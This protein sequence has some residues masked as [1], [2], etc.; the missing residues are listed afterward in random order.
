MRSAPA[1]RPA[2]L[3]R[4]ALLAL[5]VLTLAGAAYGL[6]SEPAGAQ[7]SPAAGPSFTD[8]QLYRDDVAFARH[9]ST[10]YARVMDEQR[11]RSYPMRPFVTVRP[12]TLAFLLAG[13]PGG[14]TTG[15][16]LIGA[17]AAAVVGLWTVRLVGPLGAPGAAVSGVALAGGVVAAFTP[18]GYLM[19]ECWAGLL[20]ALS[21]GLYPGDTE[22]ARTPRLAASIAAALAAA[23]IRELA[24]PYLGVMALTALAERRGKEA[25]AWL[26]AIG[27]YLLALAAHALMVMRHTL[28]ADPGMDWVRL[29]GWA[30]VLAADRW[31]AFM[32]LEPWLP[33][34]LIPTAL[35][36]SVAWGGPVGRRLAFTLIGYAAGFLVVGRPENLYWGLMIAPLLPLGWAGA[37]AAGL[38][39]VIPL[40][41]RVPARRAGRLIGSGRRS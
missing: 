1:L 14:E 11:R 7:A 5:L 39:L 36:G 31:N 28:P 41:D 34:V 40:G 21:L 12:P 30:F 33:A 37:V 24:L 18:N 26:C 13:L 17:L 27:L 15:R 38:G 6:R 3:P 35:L 25:S 23:A 19:H 10:Y 22:A 29:G 32:T 20:I 8:V 9:P 16:I 4:L 2:R